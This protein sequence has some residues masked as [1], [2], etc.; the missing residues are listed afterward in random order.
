MS[1]H[2]GNDLRIRTV[3]AMLVGLFAAITLGS[4]TAFDWPIRIAGLLAFAGLTRMAWTGRATWARLP[5]AMLLNVHVLGFVPA[6]VCPDASLTA[7]SLH[8]N[9]LALPIA[10]AAGLSLI[11][12][13]FAPVPTETELG[14]TIAFRGILR[15]LCLAGVLAPLSH[16]SIDNLGALLAIAAFGSAALAE[17]IAGCRTG[18]EARVWV[19]EAIV[20]GGAVYLL[21]FG[22]LI[23]HHEFLMFTLLGVGIALKVLKECTARIPSLAVLA[24]PLGATSF[25]MPLVAVAVGVARH[26]LAPVDWLGANSLAMLMAAAFY[27]WRGIEDERKEFHVLAA[28]VLNIALALLWRELAWSD[29]QFFMVPIGISILT[30]VELFHREIPARFRNS[31]RYAGALVILVSP[32]FHIVG[33]SWVH[34]LTLMIASVAI[35][36]LG[37]GL[38]VRA[39]LYTGTAF[40]VADLVALVVRGSVDNPNLLWIAGVLVGAG[41]V[42][43]GAYCEKHREDLALRMHLLAS[44]LKTWQ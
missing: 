15:G 11:A 33:G 36:L 38:R 26:F 42:A 28:I 20:A 19:G 37:I 27:F 4:L 44:T 30:L 25:V 18:S 14:P 1:G 2:F 13:Q 35:V 10:V 22:V 29:P 34:L 39:M 41:I 8:G 9:A 7:L 23:V 3:K 6:L 43:L 32:T 31:L 5:L 40:L 12:W 21:H 17:F 16:P 24:R